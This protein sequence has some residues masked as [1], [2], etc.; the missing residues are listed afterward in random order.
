M[1]YPEFPKNGDTIGFVAPSFGCTTEPYKT[2]FM[3]ALTRFLKLGYETKTARNCYVSDGIG[4]SSTPES[5]GSELNE[6]YIDPESKALIS[7]GG[8]ELMCEV[9][10][11]M[12]FEAVKTASPKWFMGYS[13]NTNFTFLSAILAD[14]ASIYGPCAPSFGMDPWDPSLQDALDLLTGKKLTFR[15][16]PRWELES[17]R[18]EEH[19]T[20]PYH[21]T[22]E[23]WVRAYVNG[24]ETEAPV[25]FSGRL[26]GG[27]IDCLINLSGTKYD[28]VAEFAE[29][30]KEDGLIWFLESCELNNMTIRRSLWNFKEAGWFKYVK[31]FMIGRPA[32]Y[33]GETL[34]GLDQY[35]ACVDVLADFGVPILMDVD[36][37]HLPPQIPLITGAYANVS[38]E[39]HGVTV[40]HILK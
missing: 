24:T 33:Y 6:A 38:F 25:N 9:V 2:G 23:T 32:T 14:T 19:P 16:Y 17:L 1:R 27:C 10:S 15:S 35:R 20:V 4:I 29:R 11:F 5:C 26:I 3:K 36:F 39:D 34:M 7:C 21:L 28:K 12:D 40:E 37:G 8:G 13:D 22:E 31:G 18:D 30:Y